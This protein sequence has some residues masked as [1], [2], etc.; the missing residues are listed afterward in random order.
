LK[1]EPFTTNVLHMENDIDEIFKKAIEPLESKPSDDFWRKAAEDVISRGSKAGENKAS[2]WKA[3]VLTL[4]AALLVLGYFAYKIQNRL[5]NVEQQMAVIKNSEKA[6][7]SEKNVIKKTQDNNTAVAVNNTAKN[8]DDTYKGNNIQD[9]NKNK[10]STGKTVLAFSKQLGAM[11]HQADDNRVANNQ[12]IQA[13]EPVALNK[14]TNN[15]NTKDVIPTSQKAILNSTDTNQLHNTD[16]VLKGNKTTPAI[17]ADTT[18]A[19]SNKELTANNN[20][21]RFS[22]S[23]FFSPDFMAGYKFKSTNSWGSQAENLIKAEEKQ[24]FSY[25]A[26]AKAE[27]KLSSVFSVS[28][29]IA[30]QS[31]SFNVKPG[32]VYAQKQLNGD[33]GYCFTT[34]SGTVECPYYGVA[35]IGD[36][37]KMSASSTR[38]Y[39]EIP[40][41]VKYSF[42]NKE[43]YQFYFA[44]AIETNICVRESTTMA[45]QDFCG[46]NGVAVVN[47]TENSKSIYFSYYLSVGANYKIGEYLSIYVEPGLHESITAIDDNMPAITYPRLISITTG[48]TYHLR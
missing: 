14:V 35:N 1:I 6:N 2:R 42:S 36:S 18:K 25:T 47:G 31:F 5:V 39:L 4:A 24:A 34:S 21:S 22:V 43:K 48:L 37:L 40:L 45:W 41:Q 11:Q 20:P 38:A 17:L 32:T 29:G 8:S 30:Y 15:I 12:Q 3:I 44:G 23:V 16:Y 26:G 27:Y 28:A 33:A 46:Q 7:V 10:H 9:K 13:S 19:I